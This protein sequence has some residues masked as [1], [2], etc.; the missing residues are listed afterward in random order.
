MTTV[1]RAKPVPKMKYEREQMAAMFLCPYRHFGFGCSVYHHLSAQSSSQTSRPP[2]PLS[3]SGKNIGLISDLPKS[4][5][6]LLLFV[7][8][9]YPGEPIFAHVSS[10]SDFKK[11]FEDYRKSYRQVANAVDGSV[12]RPFRI[13]NIYNPYKVPLN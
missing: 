12:A 1:T 3:V 10:F 4:P 2:A 11:R 7:S 5:C 13:L 6:D 8:V 9:L